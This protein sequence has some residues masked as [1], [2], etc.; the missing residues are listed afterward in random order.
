MPEI[1]SAPLDNV[2]N[3]ESK[4]NE[5]LS[6]DTCSNEQREKIQ[7]KLKHITEI[8]I[9]NY[10]NSQGKKADLDTSLL[11][12]EIED[13]RKDLQG[14]TKDIAKGF[15]EYVVSTINSF[16]RAIKD[17]MALI[18]NAKNELSK[19]ENLGQEAVS[20]DEKALIVSK[21]SFS[22]WETFKRIRKEGKA[23][24]SKKQGIL[25]AIKNSCIEVY[26]N[27]E[28]KEEQY[29]RAE[30]LDKYDIEYRELAQQLKDVKREGAILGTR[31]LEGIKDMF[32]QVI[33]PSQE[34]TPVR[35]NSLVRKV[36]RDEV[37]SKNALARLTVSGLE[38]T[39]EK[40][41]IER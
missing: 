41:G 27:K 13:T 20:S 19:G 8:I 26:F 6:K 17:N 34:I 3:F 18:K 11:K 32:N 33:S 35:L 25:S 39:I 2:F 15:N 7:E 10:L 29:K 21:N 5:D 4:L 1:K 22:F 23:D 16:E 9:D 14:K 36:S 40:E 30:Q 24:P 28:A 12:K 37:W 31:G 38:A